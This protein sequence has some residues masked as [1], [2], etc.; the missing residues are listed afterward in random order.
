MFIFDPRET[1]MTFASELAPA[2]RTAMANPIP[3]HLLVRFGLRGQYAVIVAVDFH[4]RSARSP[5][6]SMHRFSSLRPASRIVKS[7]PRTTRDEFDA[8]ALA[9]SG[10]ARMYGQMRSNA[11]HGGS[12]LRLHTIRC[13]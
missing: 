4:R 9:D 2:L 5:R 13:L 12:R 8:T 10:C 6:W 7:L 1:S 11:F 3:D